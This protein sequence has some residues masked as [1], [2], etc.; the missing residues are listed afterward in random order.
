MAPASLLWLMGAMA[1]FVL[2]NSTLRAYAT[3]SQMPV[4]VG[5]LVLFTCG[6][7]MM[8]RIMR[9]QGLA[10]AI[11]VSSVLQLLLITAVAVLWFGER[12]SGMQLVGMAFGVVAV[13]LI[14]WP[15]GGRA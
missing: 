12:P 15:Q 6:N 2:A 10:L 9:E 3:S 11:S 4:L 7:L 13:V 8:V 1:V 14:A 5:A